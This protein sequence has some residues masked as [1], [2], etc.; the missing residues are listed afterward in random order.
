MIQHSAIAARSLPAMD[1]IH[2]DESRFDFIEL[3]LDFD[4]DFA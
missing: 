3:D 2:S 4:L 1:L